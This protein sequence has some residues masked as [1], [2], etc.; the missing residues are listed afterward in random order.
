MSATRKMMS[1]N[2]PSNRV[3]STFPQV[4]RY[5]FKLLTGLYRLIFAIKSNLALARTPSEQLSF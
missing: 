3:I 1:Q 2:V 5:S 4:G